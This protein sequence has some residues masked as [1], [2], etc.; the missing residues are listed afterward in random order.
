MTDEMDRFQ[1][2]D[3]LILL[4]YVV[5]TLMVGVWQRKRASQSIDE[6]FLSGRTLPWWLAG[7]SMV[8]TSF[9]ADTPLFVAGVVREH[10]IWKNWVWWCFAVSGLL[11]VFLFA[12]WWR[13]GGVMTKAELAELRY[14]ADAGL[15]RGFLGGVHA[16]IINPWTM[17]WVMLAARKIAR[18]LF[19]LEEDEEYLAI[20]GAAGLCV[21]YSLLGGFRGVV[22]TDFMQFTIAA[23]GAIALAL[24]SWSEVGGKAALEQA[25][26]A[27]GV[28]T[29]A[30]LRFVPPVGVEQFWTVP[31]A[32]F[33]VYLG[34]SWWASENVDGGAAAIQRISASR[35]PRHGVYS[36][37]W[38]NVLHY[39]LRSWPWIIVG[40][41]SLLVLPALE[42]SAPVG[43]QVKRIDATQVE[44]V[45]DG[46]E[47][48]AVSLRV[49]ASAEDWQPRLLVAPESRVAAGAVLARTDAESAYVVMMQRYLPVGLFGLV[50]VSLLAAFMSTIDTHVNLA[51][52]FFVND[53]YARFLRPR[54]SPEHYVV[55][56]RVAGLVVM[57][58]A[59]I[60]A[61][62]VESIREMFLLF[63][64]FL[65]G[66]GP[67]YLLRW[68]WW[69]VR[70]G[71]E[72]A[73]M[74]ASMITSVTLTFLASWR[75]ATGIPLWPDTVLSPAGVLSEEGRLA[76]V[77]VVSCAVALVQI[78]VARRP[79]PVSLVPFYR[80]VRPLGAWGPVAA[81]C[82]DVRER[83]SLRGALVSVAGGLALI[84]G[85]LFG[86][87]EW[88][89]GTP[90]GPINWGMGAALVGAVVVAN[91]LR[92]MW[93]E[94][95]DASGVDR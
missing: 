24:V 90:G 26:A 22:L 20:L 46:G 78:V 84:Y 82:P 50:V 12:R 40:L 72:I 1:A 61:L 41:C 31:L 16:F 33:A 91:G 68:L 89:L 55:V 25:Q 13:R 15:L 49:P 23:I 64:A 38:F 58:G 19:G 94:G 76:L 70:A 6:Y 39:C 44:I 77:A 56:S 93:E 69:R 86:I 30:T 32:A 47:R 95:D 28:I 29:D 83:E 53:I 66:V 80:R 18:V 42:V 57:S 73:A 75:S 4:A 21:I 51:S 11:G 85:L 35:N 67:V 65:G 48:H 81:L 62:W 52:S 10:G 45:A 63:L 37:L 79:D 59:A 71:T 54:A 36:L 3:W 92:R 9:A 34:V 87:G 88:I 8:A 7:T 17:C 60:V 27:G 74:M 5:F 43:G 14:G 2:L